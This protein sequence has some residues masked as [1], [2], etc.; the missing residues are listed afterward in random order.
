MKKPINRLFIGFLLLIKI[1]ISI[2]VSARSRSRAGLSLG[3][4]AKIATKQIEEVVYVQDG[5]ESE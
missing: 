1:I 5:T 4:G 2:I 3:G